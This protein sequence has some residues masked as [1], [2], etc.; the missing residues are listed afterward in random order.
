MRY[1]LQLFCYNS[2]TLLSSIVGLS[3]GTDDSSLKEA[4]S[5]FGDITEGISTN[6][7]AV[8]KSID[9][10]T[11]NFLLLAFYFYF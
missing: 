4:F 6:S 2:V 3:W 10:V 7:Y 1:L 9:L 8:V 11:Y 5:N